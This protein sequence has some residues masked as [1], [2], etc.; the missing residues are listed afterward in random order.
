MKSIVVHKKIL[1]KNVFVA[2][3]IKVLLL[4]AT[5]FNIDIPILYK[6]MLFSCLLVLKVRYY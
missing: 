5:F 2:N 6:I 4:V 1:K 3:I